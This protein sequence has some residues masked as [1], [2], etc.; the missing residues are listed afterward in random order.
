MDRF[1]CMLIT[2][3]VNGVHVN[4]LTD[5]DMIAHLQGRI[6]PDELVTVEAFLLEANRGDD[7]YVMLN[8][9]VVSFDRGLLV[10]LAPGANARMN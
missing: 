5:G 6:S 3:G 4:R 10:K 2:N 7:I 9:G 8:K 1:G